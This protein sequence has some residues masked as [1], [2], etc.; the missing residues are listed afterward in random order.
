MALSPM[1]PGTDPVDVAR[2]CVA[3]ARSEGAKLSTRLWAQR[4]VA[5]FTDREPS[6][7]AR[8]GLWYVGALARWARSIRPLREP[9][10]LGE[11]VQAPWRTVV[12]GSGDCDDVATAVA[13]FAK[14]VG[15]PAII[16]VWPTGPGAAHV[17]A[18]V[19]DDWYSTLHPHERHV[20][21]W[22]V[23]QFGVQP[24]KPEPGMT[25]LEV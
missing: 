11:L 3:V 23:D 2:A 7:A 6:S 22:R 24:F 9:A 18:V 1:T 21:L 4:A 19:G 15:L 16:A 10:T 17:A 20:G 12:Y 5:P 8:S 14:V 13:A 25:A